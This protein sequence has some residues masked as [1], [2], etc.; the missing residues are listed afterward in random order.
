MG[1]SE[2]TFFEKTKAF[3]S[4]LVPLEVKLAYLDE[5]SLRD[6]KRRVASVVL[7]RATQGKNNSSDVK[8]LRLLSEKLDKTPKKTEST[9]KSRF[10]FT[11][12][13]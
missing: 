3:I 1:L 13:N 6:E 9:Q 2:P 8:K 7:L 11:Q 12:Q 4:R 5:E 10:A